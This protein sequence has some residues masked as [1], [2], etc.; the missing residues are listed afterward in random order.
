[1]WLLLAATDVAGCIPPAEAV[2]AKTTSAG[3]RFL[4]A[5]CLIR[6]EFEGR[7]LDIVFGGWLLNYAGG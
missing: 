4:V 1:M 3:I 6:T 7:P 5:D 2:R